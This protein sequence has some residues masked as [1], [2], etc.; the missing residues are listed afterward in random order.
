MKKILFILTLVVSFGCFGQNNFKLGSYT[1]LINKNIE[2]KYKIPLTPFQKVEES[3]SSQGNT[4]LVSAFYART[5]A[6]IVALQIYATTMPPQYKNF[7]WKVM[8]NSEQNSKKF[9]NSFLGASNNTTLKIVKFRV[10]TINEKVFLE[11]QSNL[12]VS[13][14]T[15]KQI[16]WIT[17]YKNTF[18][19]V[20]GAT[21]IDSFDKNLPFFEKFSQSVLIN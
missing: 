3:F 13:G 2:F 10:K 7:D 15:Q 14:V 4:N 12:T 6:N 21:L 18:V 1:K 16:N 20:V 17:I 11:V 19:N 9:L 5:S 8:I